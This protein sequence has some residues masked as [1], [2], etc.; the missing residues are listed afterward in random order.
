MTTPATWTKASETTYTATV[1]G[2]TLYVTKVETREDTIARGAKLRTGTRARTYYT[3]EVARPGERTR[4][5]G[6]KHSTLR[7][8][9]DAAVNA[10][11]NAAR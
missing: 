4:E 6:F 7:A 3:A 11:V 9:Q 8:A 2:A 1:N 5:V 10:A